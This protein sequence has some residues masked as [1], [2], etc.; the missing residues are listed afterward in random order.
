MVRSALFGVEGAAAP[1]YGELGQLVHGAGVLAGVDAQ[2]AHAAVRE[3]RHR[4]RLPRIR[5]A[6]VLEDLRWTEHAACQAQKH[7]T[8]HTFNDITRG[9][10]AHMA[11]RTD[12]EDCASE[13]GE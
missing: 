3:A 1:I 8:K 4:R 5:L 12:I 13:L 11:L 10:T 2:R 6:D 9:C 7:E